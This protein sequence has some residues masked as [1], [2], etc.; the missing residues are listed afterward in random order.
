[1]PIYHFDKRPDVV[2][3]DSYVYEARYDTVQQGELDHCGGH[4]GQG[5]DYHYHFAPV[6]LLDDHDLTLP[7]G[8]TLGGASIFY[9]T[10]GDDYYGEGRYNAINNLPA[11][12]LDDCNAVRQPDGSY[13]YY[14]THEPP[15]TVGCHHE[16]VDWS[17]QVEPRQM[18]P[19][20]EFGRDAQR[21]I[22][23]SVE[24]DVRTLL[25]ETNQGAVKA[26]VYQPSA[27]GVDCWDFEFRRNPDQ[28]APTETYC[29][30]D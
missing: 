19:L 26:I 10:G 29:R 23:L 15:Y 1:V 25:F 18:R 11:E 14:T 5:E 7:I 27:A 4:A 22:G 16:T 20:G 6:C 2:L 28:A 9:G 13:V 24:G 21:I 17:R 12:P 30:P 3:D 8:F